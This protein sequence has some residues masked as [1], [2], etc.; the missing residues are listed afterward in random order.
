MLHEVDRVDLIVDRIFRLE[1]CECRKEFTQVIK[2]ML[3]RKARTTYA[4]KYESGCRLKSLELIK[5]P[6]GFDL[7]VGRD[8]LA[9]DMALGLKPRSVGPEKLY[10]E[11]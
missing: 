9:C 6:S 3:L 4:T 11:G 10:L 7:G 2:I 5:R 8:R 1:P